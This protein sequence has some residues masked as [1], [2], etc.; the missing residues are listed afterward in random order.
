MLERFRVPIPWTALVKRT[1]GEVFT[2]NCLGLAAELAFYFFLALFPAL[3]V[4]VALVSFLPIEG[5]LDTITASLARV[6]PS[7]VLILVK[8]QVLKIAHDNNGGLLTLGMIG[9]IWST[10]S[11]V[12]AIIDTL[13]QA[14]D[15][16]EGRAWWK[17]QLIALALTFAL[18]LFI[19]VSF[20][21]VLVGPTLAEHAAAWLHVGPA[22]AWTLKI[23]QWP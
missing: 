22:F 19:V 4:L 20:A 15:I 7:E 18:A 2:D 23:V 12:T 1:A 17:V 21:L 10:S 3:L 9:T 16:Q 6:A 13:N 11:G 8:D 14:Y 5:L